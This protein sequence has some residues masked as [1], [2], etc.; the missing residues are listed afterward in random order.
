VRRLKLTIEY[1][2]TLF[3]GW[4]V[5]PTGERTVQGA[6]QAA[7]AALPGRHGP[8]HGA[9]R[10]DTGVHAL[11]MTAH[12]DSDVAIEPRKLRL[13]LN[14]HLPRDVAVLAV[15]EVDDA[16]EAQF[17]CLYR[18]YLYRMRVQRDDAR[19]IALDRHRVLSV[20]RTLDVAAMREA[21]AA[22]VGRHDFAAFASRETRSTVRT[23]YLC[24][25]RGEGPE[26]HLHVAAD[27][28]LR[29]MVR[30]LVGTLLW[31][32]KGRLSPADFADVLRGRDRGRAG[33]TVGAQ[34][35]YF[36]EAG[37]EPWEARR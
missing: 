7:F 15:E 35:L 1:D 3:R 24:E 6:L 27:G 28:F 37:Y 10:T 8:V 17:G 13:A 20:F 11:A 25:L 30:T 22:V 23:V 4:Q 33:P 29:T 21:A 19:G 14:A 16:F 5:Q 18:R 9:G 32:G 12:V 31:V 36:V 26:L 34:G 2:G